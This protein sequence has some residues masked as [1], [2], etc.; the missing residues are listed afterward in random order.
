M[1]LPY[2]L[3]LIELEGRITEEKYWAIEILLQDGKSALLR[4]PCAEYTHYLGA[5]AKQLLEAIVERANKP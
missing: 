3:R 2:Y 1:T 5:S 4:M